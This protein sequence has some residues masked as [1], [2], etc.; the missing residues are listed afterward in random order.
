MIA[1]D[2]RGESGVSVPCG[3]RLGGT[4]GQG[5]ERLG[6]TGLRPVV[7]SSDSA[8]QHVNEAARSILASDLTTRIQ[9]Q[10]VGDA[11]ELARTFNVM[12]GRLEAVSRSQRDFVHVVSH[13][14]RGPLT[15]C[16][17]HLE[18]LDDDPKRGARRRRS[19]WTSSTGWRGSWTTCRLLAD[20]EQPDFIEREWIELA[21]FGH[22]SAAKA[23]E[24]WETGVGS[25]SARPRAPSSP[26]RAASPR[27]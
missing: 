1:Q 3:G 8:L 23:S 13:E 17:G 14:L 5:G 12:L 24:C 25:S 6:E 11:A 21:L 7:E 9:V 26:T 22:E 19:C 4:A 20:A 27:R 10:G 2:L 15:I 18:L 16:R